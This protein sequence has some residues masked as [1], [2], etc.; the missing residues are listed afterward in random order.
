MWSSTAAANGNGAPSI[1]IDEVGVGNKEQPMS[2]EL[3]QTEAACGH[4]YNII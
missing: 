4:I 3:L 2:F 1:L